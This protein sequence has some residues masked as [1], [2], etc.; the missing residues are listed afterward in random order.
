MKKL[1]LIITVFLLLTF[2]ATP[3][4]AASSQIVGPEVVYKQK[5]SLVT[6]TDIVNLY[7]SYGNH[8]SLKYDGYTGYG[9]TI[10]SYEVT[11]SVSDGLNEIG[12]RAVQIYV[13]DSFGT[14]KIRFITDT[15]S[16]YTMK[17]QTLYPREIV[18][19]LA[20]VNLIQYSS[21]TS[22]AYL[23]KDDYSSNASTPGYYQFNFRVIDVSGFDK[24]FQSF[25][26]VSA[27]NLLPID[28][29]IDM[30][31]SGGSFISGTFEFVTNNWLLI[32]IGIGILLYFT[33]SKKNVY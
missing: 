33:K 31:T 14:N 25:I 12:Q 20:T 32:L 16:I 13:V 22:T 29:Q 24:T 23:I 21:Q 15:K 11:L 27:D 3:T 10:G 19:A 5:D 17:D 30:G 4:Y 6:I 2:I 1:I 8:V 26:Y 18:I 9:A 7:S 28:G